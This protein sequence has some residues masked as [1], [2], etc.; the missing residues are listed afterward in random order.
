MKLRSRITLL[1][2]LL[3]IVPV[4][5]VGFLAYYTGRQ[6]IENVEINHLVSTNLMKSSELTRWIEGNQLRM[7]ELAQRPLVVQNSAI[8]AT[9]DPSGPAYDNARLDLENDHLRPRIT[10]TGGFIEILV[11]SPDSGIVLASSDDTQEGKYHSNQRFYLEG[12][13]HTYTQG[14]FYSLPLQQTTMVVSTPVKD[15]QGKLVAVLAGRLDL[16]DLS[17][18]MSAQSGLRLT[19]KTYLVNKSNFFVTEP[20]SGGGYALKKTVRTEGVQAGLS[21]SD[22]VGFYEDYLNVPVIGAYKWLP[23]YNM[24]LITEVD[25]AE[26]Y[27]RI[28]SMAATMITIVS[29]LALIVVVASFLLARTITQPLARLVAGAAAIGRGNLDQRVGTT[30]KDEIGE[31]SR[32]FD[33]MAMELKETTVSLD[34]LEQRIRERTTQL[35][36]ANRELEA[37]SYSVSH[38]LRA[39]LRAIDGY[40]RI[41]QEEYQQLLDAEG[42]RICSVISESARKMSGLI[43]DLLAF[44]R[45]GRSAINPGKLDMESLANSVFQDLTTAQSRKRIDFKVDAAPPV[46][47]D[48]SLLR[49][50]WVNLISNAIKFSSR[51]RRAVIRV[52]GENTEGEVVYSVQ[53]NGVGFDMQ[54][55]DKLF[56]VFQR[57][58]SVREFEGNGVG[59]ALVQR[60]IHRHGGRVWAEGQIGKGA[61]FNFSLPR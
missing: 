32:A 39:P 47:G 57:L 51:R 14:V 56:G 29:L 1:F 28:D 40:T 27:S 36:A 3:A 26:A 19:E 35:E 24:C 2:A 42:K 7:E 50:V 23:Q 53:D 61:T 18:I 22:G 13:T 58:H 15:R 16:S 44:S 48:M 21:G 5:I 43:D 20:S 34:E 41:L 31:L 37:F 11:M 54:Y 25:Q 60:V 30:A 9:S 8:M 17:L 59:L 55:A 52:H 4:I 38:D 6:S 46:M 10:P 33:R 12:K 45:L 49:Q